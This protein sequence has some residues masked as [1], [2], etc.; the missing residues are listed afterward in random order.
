[1]RPIDHEELAKQSVLT[2]RG[3]E[4]LEFLRQTMD[5]RD[6]DP[7]SSIVTARDV[8]FCA[9]SNLESGVPQPQ[10]QVAIMLRQI[11]DLLVNMNANESDYF[12]L[13]FM[14]DRP[15]L[16]GRYRKRPATTETP[17]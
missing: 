13:K 11:A 6:C 7:A 3:T 10:P 2:E 4:H 8:L 1:M 16:F 17:K 9:A 14:L 5:R 12:T 15:D